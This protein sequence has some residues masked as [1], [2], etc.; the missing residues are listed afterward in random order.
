MQHPIA[1]LAGATYG[2]ITRR[3]LYYILLL[4]FALAIL[5]SN[6]LTLFSFYQK[7]NMVREMGMA[8]L[9]FWAFIILTLTSG[10]VVTQELEDRTAVTL[11]AKP[12][13]RRDFL[14]G[15][16]VGIVL[17]LAPGL[18]VLA[19]VLFLTLWTMASPLLDLHDKDVS[20]NL[21]AGTGA[22]ASAWSAVWNQFV[23]A[24]GGVV[25]EG[26]LLSFLQAA[27][28]AALS[29]SFSAFFPTVVSVAAT[30]LA[31]ILGNISSYMV[32]SLETMDVA[33][34]T[35]T[36]RALSYLTPN[37]GYF[38]LQSAFSE[39]KIISLSYLGMALSY[40]ALF[41]GAVFLVSCSLFQK[42]EVR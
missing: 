2:E 16:Y 21:A 11:L 37:F 26:A 38:N 7:I 28:L 35:W 40:S 34:L 1:T 10:T 36:G 33:P 19:G 6:L 31:F 18:F 30:T 32:A 15:K 17:S 5:G 13:R 24:Q 39:G 22:F 4:S 20:R 9:T 23:L 8:T 41:V 3:P 27:I 25:L 14:L 42:R 12:L 29:V